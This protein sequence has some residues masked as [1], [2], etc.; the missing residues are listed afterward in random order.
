MSSSPVRP[1]SISTTASTRR[2]GSLLGADLD[3]QVR[4]RQQ[5]FVQ[6]DQLV[7]APARGSADDGVEGAG[8]MPATGTV[9][10]V[11]IPG[12]KSRFAARDAWIYLPPAYLTTPRAELPVIMLMAGQPGEPRDWFEAGKLGAVMDA[13]AAQHQGLAPVVVVVDH[14][15]DRFANPGCVDSPQGNVFTYL[16][17][18]VPDWIKANLQVA[19]DTQSGP[20]AGFPTAAPAR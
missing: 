15:G 18:D 20:S 16:T 6:P 10:T 3:N 11:A 4:L 2:C 12:T 8:D 19:P 7:K 14:L 9:S 5:T 1:P 17:P 13:F